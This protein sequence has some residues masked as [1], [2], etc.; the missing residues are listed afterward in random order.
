[1]GDFLLVVMGARKNRLHED[2]G[3]SHSFHVITSKWGL[4]DP[5]YN[6]LQKKMLCF[7][8]I[9][10]G[11]R[12]INAHVEA[13]QARKEKKKNMEQ[14]RRILLWKT[15][16]TVNKLELPQCFTFFLD[17]LGLRGWQ[18]KYSLGNQIKSCVCPRGNWT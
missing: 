15:N 6:L 17:L 16:E 13:K 18:P 14:V 9:T 12:N 8:V 3:M 1:M 5:G 10:D 2:R 7:V 4:R 11:F